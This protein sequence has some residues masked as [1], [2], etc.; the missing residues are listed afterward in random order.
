MATERPVGSCFRRLEVVG[1]LAPIGMHIKRVAAEIGAGV[2]GGGAEGNGLD[3]RCLLREIFLKTFENKIT[4]PC[5]NVGSL[6]EVSHTFLYLFMLTIYLSTHSFTY[7]S[8]SSLFL[9]PSPFVLPSL[10]FPPLSLHPN[11]CPLQCYLLSKSS[12]R[13][14]PPV[15]L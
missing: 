3:C 13:F 14:F 10:S 2:I 6:L 5:C 8:D 4:F 12:L 11:R 15:L 9:S 1:I 7:S